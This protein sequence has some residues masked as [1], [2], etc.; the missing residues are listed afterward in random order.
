[1]SLTMCDVKTWGAG[2]LLRRM[3]GAQGAGE[4]LGD[5]R[6]GGAELGAALDMERDRD[7]GQPFPGVHGR[8]AGGAGQDASVTAGGFEAS[9]RRADIPGD[10]IAGSLEHDLGLELPADRQMLLQQIDV[11]HVIGWAELLAGYGD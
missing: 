6:D 5:S 3:L 4:P 8:V 2:I 1:M 10:R 7:R 11:V 9:H